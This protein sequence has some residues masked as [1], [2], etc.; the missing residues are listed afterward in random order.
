MARTNPITTATSWWLVAA[1][2][3]LVSCDS[4][5]QPPQP[6]QFAA[7]R[8]AEFDVGGAVTLLEASA[9]QG[10]A[11]APIPL[12]YLRGLI[13][14]REAFREGGAPD[15]LAPVRGS[16]TA[17]GA[18]SKGQPGEA[19][20]A[21]LV[22]QA[23]A[24]AA[25][26]ERDEMRLYIESATQ[27]EVVQRAAGQRGAPLVSAAEVAGDLW[28]QV[29]RYEDARAAYTAAA[30]HVG[31]TPRILSGLARAARRLSDMAAACAAYQRLVDA[32]GARPAAPAE[33]VEARAYLSG[34]TP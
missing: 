19:E 2:L 25:Q 8:A 34:C 27:M 28:L 26:S 6:R 16:I 1:L 22:L 31:F 9:S 17:L 18:L 29:S 24:A 14:A 3:L 12:L 30:E 32:W 13:A 4:A 33:I 10:D 15:A 21:R 20:I 23:A 7:T 5:A 11:S